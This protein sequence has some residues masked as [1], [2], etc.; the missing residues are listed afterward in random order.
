LSPVAWGTREYVQID[1]VNNSGG[2][3]IPE[4]VQAERVGLDFESQV[5]KHGVAIKRIIADVDECWR[6][7]G[8]GG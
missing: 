8:Q 7:E 2:Y 5:I 4:T 1:A 6:F 3:Q